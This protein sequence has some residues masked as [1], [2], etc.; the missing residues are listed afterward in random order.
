MLREP[1]WRDMRLAERGIVIDP[2]G[3]SLY[4]FPDGERLLLGEDI[5][6]SQEEIRR[7]SARRRPRPARVRGGARRARRG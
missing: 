1:V 7:F 2:A 6:A 3:P 4:G 5:A